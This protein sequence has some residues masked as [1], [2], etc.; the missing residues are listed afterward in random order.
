MD[1]SSTYANARRDEVRV[2]INRLAILAACL[3]LIASL[4][5]ADGGAVLSRVHTGSLIVT[6]FSTSVPL[7]VGAA[8]LSVMVQTAASGSLELDADIDLRLSK[9]GGPEIRIAATRTR[10]ANKLLYTAQPILPSPGE[11]H[12]DVHVQANG[13]TIAVPVSI[14]VL[15]A[16]PPLVTYWPY[17]LAVPLGMLLFILNQWLKSRMQPRRRAVTGIV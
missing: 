16:D 2:F 10:S 4:S 15:T 8:D 6:V 3:H 17:F 9:P 5:I 7:R 14:S 12:L 1:S 13:N 11:W